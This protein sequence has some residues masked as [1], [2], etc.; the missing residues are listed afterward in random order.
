[1]PKPI[2]GRGGKARETLI[3]TGSLGYRSL[4]MP[5]K[6]ELFAAAYAVESERLCERLLRVSKRGRNTGVR[7]EAALREL[8]ALITD[9]PAL[10]RALLLE[11]DVAGGEAA[12]KRR[13]VLGCLTRAVDRAYRRAGALPAPPRT[14]AAFVVGSIVE[15][16]SRA[17][18]GGS[19]ADFSASIP[20]LAAMAGA[21]FESAEAG[22]RAVT[23][24]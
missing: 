13:E 17:L 18:A 12:R 7:L 24:A 3:R 8:A 1:M 6:R 20:E 15:S 14:A 9:R 23:A 16:L 5:E 4:E 2:A 11:A 21:A 10:A 19:P 22:E